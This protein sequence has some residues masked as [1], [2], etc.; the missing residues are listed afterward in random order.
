[1][2]IAKN[3]NLII[4]AKE[5]REEIEKALNLIVYTSI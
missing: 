2:W 5:T 4:L 1:M 3:D